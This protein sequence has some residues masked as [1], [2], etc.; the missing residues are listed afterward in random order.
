MSDLLQVLPIIDPPELDTSY[1]C[2]PVLPNA[3][4]GR[5][6]SIIHVG[7][8]SSGKRHLSAAM[9]YVAEQHAV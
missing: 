5:G 3:R 9:K 2:N 6:A 8:P 7:P 4:K 1:P